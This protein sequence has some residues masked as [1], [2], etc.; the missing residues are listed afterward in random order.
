MWLFCEQTFKVKLLL[1]EILWL[2]IFLLL[3]KL[4]INK[5]KLY[6]HKIIFIT[7]YAKRRNL[8]LQNTEKIKSDC[9]IRAKNHPHI[10]LTHISYY[11][12]VSC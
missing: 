5:N 6:N 11:F 2:N 12:I 10:L 3:L 8:F 7:V 4:F 1:Y 9:N